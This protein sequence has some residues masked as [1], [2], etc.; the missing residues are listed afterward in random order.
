MK[1]TETPNDEYEKLMG[2]FLNEN[3]GEEYINMVVSQSCINPDG[4]VDATKRYR[5]KQKLQKALKAYLERK[6]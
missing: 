6:N 5:F 2:Y 3:G 4:K 1:E